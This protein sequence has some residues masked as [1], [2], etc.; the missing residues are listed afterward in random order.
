[1]T[2][3]REY[4]WDDRAPAF[5]LMGTTAALIAE[6]YCS[7]DVDDVTRARWS[8]G[9]ALM[10]E[11]DTYYDDI[12]SNDDAVDAR[13]D[14]LSRL[15]SYD[16]F[17]TLYPS[18]A[19]GV[20][21][22][23]RRGDLLKR[24]EHIM[25]LG[26]YVAGATTPY[27]YARLRAAEARESA[28]VT[29][30]VSTDHVHEQAAFRDKF[31]PVFQSF[32]IGAC[33]LDSTLDGWTDYKLGKASIRPTVGY[34]TELLRIGARPMAYGMRPLLHPSIAAQ[35]LI[36]AQQRITTRLRN[37]MTSHSTMQNIKTLF[38]K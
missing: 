30:G 31:V 10:R 5:R 28:N 38:D 33:A 9:G 13:R 17:A 22:D 23:E 25:K 32:A 14:I 34:Y 4:I 26:E 19:P 18:L 36:M 35:G 3:E 20:I 27:R 24:A 8:D 2:G 1:M 7:V 21:D 29:I 11:V 12:S 16:E 37:G 15:Q 6:K